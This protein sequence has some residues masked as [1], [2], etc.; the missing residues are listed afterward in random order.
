MQAMFV[1]VYPTESEADP[2]SVAFGNTR[3]RR[4]QSVLIG[5]RFIGPIFGAIF[6]AV[7]IMSVIASAH[8]GIRGVDVRPLFGGLEV[9]FWPP[10]L[11]FVAIAGLIGLNAGW[12][13]SPVFRVSI[14][15]LTMLWA[16]MG[17]EAA[18]YHIGTMANRWGVFSIVPF[19]LAGFLYYLG[20]RRA[21]GQAQQRAAS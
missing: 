8:C 15:V 20:Q 17:A 18:A 13:L 3:E 21:K 14:A 9:R 7:G 11:V 19:I 10:M 1:N 4:G 16:F 2:L 6:F 5:F 12:K